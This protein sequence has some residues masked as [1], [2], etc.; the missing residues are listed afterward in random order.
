MTVASVV[1]VDPDVIVLVCVMVL[2]AISNNKTQGM[3]MGM[4]RSEGCYCGSLRYCRNLKVRRAEGCG[5]SLLL[6]DSN[7]ATHNVT[8]QLRDYWRCGLRNWTSRNGDS[9]SGNCKTQSQPGYLTEV[10]GGM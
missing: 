4:L 9:G 3:N 5:L 7:E 10:H 2:L 6:C 1:V 8:E